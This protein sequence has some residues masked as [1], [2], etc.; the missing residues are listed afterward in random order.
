MS[1]DLLDEL[2]EAGAKV[3]TKKR[4]RKT[5]P[6]VDLPPDEFFETFTGFDEIAVKKAFSITSLMKFAKESPTEWLRTLVFIAE[7]RAGNP[8]AK[9]A[10]LE[11]TLG[12]VLDYFGDDPEEDEGTDPSPEE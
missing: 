2:D 5:D 1:G 9:R 11:L 3:K 6:I 8:D 12:A 4:G 10:A 7:K